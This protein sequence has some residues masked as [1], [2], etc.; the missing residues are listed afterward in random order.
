MRRLLVVT[1][2]THSKGSDVGLTGEKAKDCL[3]TR[4]Q[5]SEGWRAVPKRYDD[6][7]Y[8]GGN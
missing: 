3:D 4:P 6:A 7:A 1:S 8:S 2:F 5:A